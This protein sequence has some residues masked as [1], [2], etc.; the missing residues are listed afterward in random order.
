MDLLDSI[1]DKKILAVQAVSNHTGSSSRPSPVSGAAIN[2]ECLGIAKD[3]FQ[4]ARDNVRE[5]GEDLQGLKR[6]SELRDAGW[7]LIKLAGQWNV[8]YS[9]HSLLNLPL[10]PSL[11]VPIDAEGR[12]TSLEQPVLLTISRTAM[13]SESLCLGAILSGGDPLL[14]LL[15]SSIDSALFRKTLLMRA[16]DLSRLSMTS[17]EIDGFRLELSSGP[18]DLA[19]SND[20]VLLEKAL[21][22]YKVFIH[23]R[24]ETL[25]L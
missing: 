5:T 4:Q 11:V 19:L 15:F 22:I 20:A 2:Q 17:L 7:P 13:T 21:N 16:N 24:G 10:D 9:Y 23:S 18:H 12:P 25:A 14:A 8:N 3:I 6:L 1:L